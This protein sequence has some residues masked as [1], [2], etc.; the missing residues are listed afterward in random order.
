MARRGKTIGMTVIGS[1]RDLTH[2]IAG[3]DRL[4]P[5]DGLA[6]SCSSPTS[7]SLPLPTFRK[8]TN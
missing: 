6:D 2:P 4:F 3:V 8:L 1:K 5:P 7:L